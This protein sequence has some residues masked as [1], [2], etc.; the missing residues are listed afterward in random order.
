M[1]LITYALPI[2]PGQTS[3]AGAFGADLD[4]AG[5]RDRY[6]ELNRSAGIV[7]HQEWIQSGP[8]GDLLIVVFET[9]TPERIARPFDADDG[10]DR[11]WRERVQRIH[12]FDPAE[13][14][15]IARPTFGCDAES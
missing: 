7:R 2:L 15:R 4:A 12:G 9:P 10:Y 13:G 8:E 14:G 3:A 11:W 6:E 1:A 5:Y